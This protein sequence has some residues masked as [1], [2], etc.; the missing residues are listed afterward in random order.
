IWETVSAMGLPWAPAGQNL[1]DR[2]GKTRSFT[3][4]WQPLC[5][6]MLNTQA[7]DAS[8]RLFG[9]LL[10]EVLLGGKAAMRPFIARTG[11][12][13]VF[14]APALATLASYGAQMNFRR[15]LMSVGEN[16]LNFDDGSIIMGRADRTVLALPPWVTAGLLPAIPE[17][18]TR[19]IVNAHFR[20]DHTAE[21]PGGQPFLGLTGG[22]AQWLFVRDD[23]ASVTVSAADRLL[24]LSAEDLAGI[25]W[26]DVA[27]FLGGNPDRLPP[28]RLIKE[29]RATLAHTPKVV[30][31]R[32]GPATK[33]PWLWLAG[34]WLASPWPCTIEAAIASGLAAARLA[35][36]RDDLS[37]A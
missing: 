12:S 5:E 10:R 2:L 33:M 35:V 7:E 32:P 24:E 23:V 16:S 29:R 36:G 15:R 31:L 13:A 14:A 9:C 17:L 3:S 30:E 34:D 21:L 11:L 25:L 20:L 19:A 28:F 22:T 18:P 27:A 26:R 6:A 37:F 4:L 8:A 1:S